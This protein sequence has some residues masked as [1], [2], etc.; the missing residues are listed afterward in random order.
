MD[1]KNRFHTDQT[2]WL[3]RAE[4]VAL[5]LVLSGWVLLHHTQVDWLRFV[6]AFA[7]LDLIGYLPGALAHRRAQGKPIAPIYHH[8]YNLTH[9]YLFGG[10]LVGCWALLI[11]GP[12]L[13]MLAVPIH[14]SGD[15]GIFGNTYKP[16]GLSFEPA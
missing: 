8:A 2:W 11:G 13:A 12:E 5:L 4:H 10:L 9:S 7:V 14:L 16:V 3:V 15:R 6:V 1:S